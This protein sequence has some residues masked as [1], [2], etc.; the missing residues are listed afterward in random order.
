MQAKSFAKS[1][2]IS[3]RKMG[4]VAALVRGRKVSD[5]LVILDHTPR[6]AAPLLAKA[7]S[8]AAANARQKHNSQPED[9]TIETLDIGAGPSMKRYFSAAHGR[10]RPYKKRTSHVRI[11]VNSPEKP[12]TSNKQEAPSKKGKE[13]TV[14]KKE[15]KKEAKK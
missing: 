10:A 5:A 1:I 13:P 4:V 8:S 2:R 9:L 7:I 6:R 15:A 3:P 14:A 11:I 12:A